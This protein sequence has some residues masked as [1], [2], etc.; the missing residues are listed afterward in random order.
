VGRIEYTIEA[1]IAVYSM[2]II[3]IASTEIESIQTL[4]SKC[5]VLF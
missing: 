4:Y 1:I 3:A 5:L 2:P